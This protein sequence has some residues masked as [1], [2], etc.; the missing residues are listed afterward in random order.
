MQAL[1]AV[2]KDGAIAFEKVGP[3]TEVALA[4]A[5]AA[6]AGSAPADAPKTE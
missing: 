1:R 3:A 6:P 2:V 5:A 4:G